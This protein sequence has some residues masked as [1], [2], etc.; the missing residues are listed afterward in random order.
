MKLKKEKRKAV[1]INPSTLLLY[2]APK[3]GN[4]TMLSQLDDCL[5]IDTEKGSHMV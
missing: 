4:T 1:S 5:I 3:V 2:G